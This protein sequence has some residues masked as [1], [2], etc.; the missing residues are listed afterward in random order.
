MDRL[1]RCGETYADDGIWFCPTCQPF[2]PRIAHS[3]M[4]N[5]KDGSKLSGKDKKF[6]SQR[7]YESLG[8]RKAKKSEATIAQERGE[9]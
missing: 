3:T 8:K 1:C 5:F 6:V 7:Y 2:R 9:I 4:A